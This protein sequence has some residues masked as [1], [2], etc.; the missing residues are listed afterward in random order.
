MSWQ[1][2]IFFI[3][4]FLNSWSW[5]TPPRSSLV[6]SSLHTMNSSWSLQLADALLATSSYLSKPVLGHTCL[7]GT[8]SQWAC[9]R[10]GWSTHTQGQH[11][12]V[13][14]TLFPPMI[15]GISVGVLWK[16]YRFSGCQGSTGMYPVTSVIY[17]FHLWMGKLEYGCQ[18][19]PGRSSHTGGAPDLLSSRA[20]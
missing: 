18:V 20:A 19:H 14:L 8:N 3:I 10:A 12:S 1:L 16:G 11:Q 13:D 2:L 15:F 9:P 5:P 4:G 6:S 17:F 7:C